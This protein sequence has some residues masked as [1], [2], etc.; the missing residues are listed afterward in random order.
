MKKHDGKTAL[1]TGSTK[2]I[3]RAI[4]IR[5]ADEGANVV[6]T[7]RDEEEGRIVVK[8]IERK[9]GKALFKKADLRNV[10]VN[11]K[12]VERTIRGLPEVC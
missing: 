4:A 5:F 9:G 6:I 10:D 11:E 2:G 8:N 1:I 7:G 12:L 3:G